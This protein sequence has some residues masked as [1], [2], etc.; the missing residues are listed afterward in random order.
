MALI[1]AGLALLFKAFGWL[2]ISR[3]VIGIAMF[4][5]LIMFLRK[6]SKETE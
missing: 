3:Y 4:I 5:S 1:I 2:T 6:N